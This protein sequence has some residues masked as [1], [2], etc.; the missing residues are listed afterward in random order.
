MVRVTTLHDCYSATRGCRA[1]AAA[2]SAL[3]CGSP[4]PSSTCPGPPPQEVR[5]CT[6][7]LMLCSGA[8]W[9]GQGLHAKLGR[10]Q[11][12]LPKGMASRAGARTRI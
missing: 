4:P 1:A 6:P 3:L 11:E 10:C 2:H 5:C 7:C 12:L 8:R 9:A